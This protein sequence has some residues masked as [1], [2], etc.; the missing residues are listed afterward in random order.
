MSLSEKQSQR[1][2]RAYTDDLDP[3]S[4]AINNGDTMPA[5]YPSEKPLLAVLVALSALFWLGLALGLPGALEHYFP[6]QGALA[7]GLLIGSILIL[8]HATDSLRRAGRVASLLGH[9]VEIGPGQYPDLHARL[10]T[11]A[12][13]LEIEPA[14]RAFLFRKPS[15]GPSFGVRFAGRRYLALDAEIVGALTEH[16]GAINFFMGHALA[17]VH[18]RRA[19]LETFLLPALVLPLL[20]PAYRR[21]QVY[22]AD[23]AGLA[24]C[25]NKGDAALALALLAGGSRRFKSLDIAGYAAG[26]FALG[27]FLPSFVELVSGRPPLPKR[28]AHL[29]AAA[30][31]SELLLPRRHALAWLTALFVPYLAPRAAL[32]SRL[33]A[34]MLWAVLAVLAVHTGQRLLAQSGLI[35]MLESRFVDKVVRPWPSPAAPALPPTAPAPETVETKTDAYARLDADLKRIGDL[36]LARQRRHGGIPCELGDLSGL[37]LN[38]PARRYALSCDEPMVYTMVETGEFE[39]GRS[40]HLRAYHWKEGR[41]IPWRQGGAAADHSP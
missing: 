3:L 21:A 12:R 8:T 1:H 27:A 34:A 28:V 17:M 20:G 13:R 19:V 6:G 33:L 40:T 10:E 23:R 29:R 7:A 15:L 24:A 39:P 2:L 11:V 38:F 32:V 37:R 14:P 18:R 22:T 41:I 9:A 30:T 16:Q 36:A 4:H 25:K 26:A 35:E 31:Q 5:S